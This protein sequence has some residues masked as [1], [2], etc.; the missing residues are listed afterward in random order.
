MNTRGK[1][2]RALAASIV[3]EGKC[4]KKNRTRYAYK[5][6]R[7]IKDEIH[8]KIK[9]N[10]KSFCRVRV[11]VMLYLHPEGSGFSVWVKR[12]LAGEAKGHRQSQV[13]RAQGRRRR[14]VANLYRPV[15]QSMTENWRENRLLIRNPSF[16]AFS[17]NMAQTYT[18]NIRLG[19]Y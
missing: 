2:Q 11:V 7:K 3:R 8:L 9:I 16:K 5:T 19:C 13:S 17:A 6:H 4:L 14:R 12:S 18:V 15:A 1:K 10:C